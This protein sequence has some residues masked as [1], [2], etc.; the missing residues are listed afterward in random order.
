MYKNRK[1]IH[2][3]MD[4]FYASVEQRDNPELRGKPVA[5][6]GLPSQRGAVCAASYEARRFGIHSAMPSRS[7]IARCQHLVFIKPRFPVY[8]AVSTEIRKIFFD[9]TDLVEPLSLDEAY[10]DVTV[11]KREI[12][13]AVMIAREIRDRIRT[14]LNLTASAGISINKFLAK[15]ASNLNKPDGQSLIAPDQAEAFIEKLPIEDFYGVGPAT[16]TK[17]KALGIHT[18]ADLKQWDPSQLVAT[19]GK[20]GHYYYRVVR[21][22]DNRPVNPNRI[23][24]SIGAERSFFEDLRER[25]QMEA[26][27]EK[28]A[29]EVHERLSNNQKTGYTL[30]LK[31]KYDNYDTCTRSQ[32]LETPIKEQAEILRLAKGLLLAHVEKGRPVRLLGITLSNLVEPQPYSQ[33]SLSFS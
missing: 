3:D 22:E 18:G 16:A 2:V 21:A 20:V 33:L 24:K 32:T 31:I 29:Q 30:T 13:S 15:I 8:K 23:R 28:I 7:A 25:S 26:A 19:F 17:M 6:G 5:V 11:D 1:I 14:E 9:Y 12:G 10:L 4:A 27:L